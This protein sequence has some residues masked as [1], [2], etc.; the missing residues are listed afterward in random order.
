MKKLSLFELFLLL[1]ISMFAQV[2]ITT[3]NSAPDASAMLDIK[4]ANK[5]LLIPQV[6]LTAINAPNPVTDPAVGLL[7][8]NTATSGA[9]P[10]NVI[11]GFYYWNGTKWIAVI[12][13]QGT[14]LGDMYYWNGMQ[15]VILPAG[16]N[17]QVLTFNNSQPTWGGAQ[18]PIVSTTAIS[19]LTPVS[20]STG[21]YVS[22]DGY[23][24]VI[25]RGVCWSTS[26]NPTIA[27]NKTTDSSGTGGYISALTGLAPSTPYYVRAYA[28]NSVG[29]AYGDQL[30]FSTIAF[31]I[32]QN[33]FGGIIFYIDTTGIHGLISAT[34]DQGSAKWGCLSIIGGTSTA[35]GTGQANTTAIVNGCST[36]GIAARVCNDLVLNGYDDWFLP[37]KDEL[38]LM[39]AQ[40]TVIGGFSW[41]YW[42][43]SESNMMNAWCEDFTNGAQSTYVK[44]A[45][46][47][48]R[49]V[50]AF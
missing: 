11:P 31:A 47:K 45:S 1:S 25:A 26:P 33:L 28:T 46:W 18:L 12:S 9:S 4:S 29:T 38:N 23:A 50:R 7:I 49:A 35:I 22:S 43:S 15:W 39:Y 16:T 13:P 6:E 27:D 14:G 41:Y 24:P 32:G 42:S 19:N 5:G 30:S 21:G 34:T 44:T 8:Y 40:K 20:A 48:V 3:D 2:S 37:S 36:A 10:N 17:G